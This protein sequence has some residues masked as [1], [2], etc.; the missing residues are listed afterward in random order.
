MQR[1]NTVFSQIL[2][3]RLKQSIL[4][5]CVAFTLSSCATRSTN[6][7]R[8]MLSDDVSYILQPIPESLVNTG[9]LAL[10]K[11][12]QQGKVNAFLMQ[13]E[14]TQS[15]LLI[16]GMTVE[17][18]SL[19]SLDWNTTLATLNVDKKIAIE[20]LRVLAELQLVLWPLTEISQGL[21]QTTLTINSAGDRE[22][23]SADGIIYRISQQANISQLINHRQNYSITIEDLEHWTLP[24]E[25]TP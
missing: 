24:V 3:P 9:I 13:V 15:N 7:H 16:S 10:F 6:V 19:F 8:I 5:L 14:M 1:S 22:I 23:S 2:L 11:V 25:N 21:E 17:G 20:P 18:L 4:L 12:E